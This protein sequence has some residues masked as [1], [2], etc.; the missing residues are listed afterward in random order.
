MKHFRLRASAYLEA[1]DDRALALQLVASVPAT[2]LSGRV[3]RATT[4]FGARS[5][6]ARVLAE[7]SLPIDEAVADRVR[8]LCLLFASRDRTRGLIWHLPPEDQPLDHFGVEVVA[9]SPDESVFLRFTSSELNASTPLPSGMS[10]L[11]WPTRLATGEMLDFRYEATTRWHWTGLDRPAELDFPQALQL[12]SQLSVAMRHYRRPL[13][14]PE[15]WVPVHGDLARWNLRVSAGTT[16]VLDWEAT[17][18]G[19]PWL[20][21][22]RY[23]ATTGRPLRMPKEFVDAERP[24]LREAAAHW[25]GLL[26]DGDSTVSWVRRAHARQRRQLTLLMNS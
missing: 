25:L 14:T 6:G 3:V 22:V 23:L 10:N 2:G 9:A 18:W 21:L 7:R 19:L 20:D 24:R 5:L 12:V 4:H 11:W 13:S 1:A 16:V 8:S 15:S 17:G 26:G